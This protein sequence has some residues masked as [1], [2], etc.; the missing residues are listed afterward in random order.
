[1]RFGGSDGTDLYC[2]CASC[3][4]C[5]PLRHSSARS[6]SGTVKNILDGAPGGSLHA[7]KDG[8]DEAV[9]GAGA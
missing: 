1:M 7:P 8:T 6:M 4:T 9:L 2:L 5:A 3:L